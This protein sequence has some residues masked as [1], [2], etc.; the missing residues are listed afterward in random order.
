MR[1][2]NYI[3]MNRYLLFLVFLFS[4]ANTAFAQPKHEFRAVWV[5]TVVNIDW[6]S[7]IGLSTPEQQAEVIEL[8]NLH[9]SLGMNAIILQVRPSADAFYNSKLEPWS[10]YLSGIQGAAPNP[11]YDPLQFWI[12]ECHKRG[13]ELHAWLNPYRVAQKFDDPLS[14]NHIAFAK[15]EWILKYGNKLYF[16]PGVPETREFVAK[17]VQ[18]IVARYDVDAIHFDDYFYPYPL[19]EAFPDTT[20]FRNY[21]R[22]YSAENIGDWR[23]ENVDICIKMLNETIKATKPW[24]KFGI[25]PFGVWRNKVDDPMGSDT[26]AGATNYDHLYANIIKWQEKGWIDYCLPQLYW[27]IGHPLV[28]FTL[29]A[30]WW[31]NHTY[32]R[33][34][35]VGHGVYRI[36]ANSK[37]KEWAEADQIPKQITVLRSIPELGGSA[38]YSSKWFKGDLLGL[39][40]E[41]KQNLYRNP[42]IIP[43]MPW[44]DNVAPQGVTVLKKRGRKVKWETMESELEMDR[45][46][47]FV[48][49]LTES[50]TLP[51]SERNT[52]IFTFTKEKAIKFERI[53][54]KKRKYDVRISVLDRLNNESTVSLPVSVKL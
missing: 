29:L 13:M 22:G 54:K 50:G 46:D 48:V 49:Y 51:D 34:M 21:N 20:S 24:V 47:K 31:R 33:A 4:W 28:D 41:L 12:D 8:L 1:Q 19:Q 26:K 42:A 27:R 52:H 35:Y 43:P 36:A 23:R 44:L 38:F 53:N 5:A 25:S 3:T 18:D 37:T 11:Y 17:V 6:P 39:Q 7:K 32:G 40:D 15:P 45:A 14:E 9:K 16:D 2:Q 10:R 30:N